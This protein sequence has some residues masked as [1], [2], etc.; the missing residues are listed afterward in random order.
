MMKAL[1][2]VA[3]ALGLLWVTGSLRQVNAA[4]AVRSPSVVLNLPIICMDRETLIA[5]IERQGAFAVWHGIR[6]QTFLSTLYLKSDGSW[7]L[8][9]ERAMSKTACILSSGQQ[10]E[11]LGIG[12]I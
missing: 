2:L 3:A 6:N 4:E 8:T 12:G 1:L 9:E 10:N 5:D 11:L 7:M